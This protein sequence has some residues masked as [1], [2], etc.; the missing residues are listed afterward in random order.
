[1]AAGHAVVAAD[2]RF[3]PR[4]IIARD[5]GDGLLVPVDDTA[6]LAA[7]LMERNKKLGDS[8]EEEEDDEDW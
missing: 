4:E 3:G 6:A 1:M 8:D 7:A 2:C 5:G